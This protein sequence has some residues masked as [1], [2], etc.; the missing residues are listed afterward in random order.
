MQ[1]TEKTLSDGEAEAACMELIKAA[2]QKFAA[3][4]RS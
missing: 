3:K 2:A 4:L 1:D